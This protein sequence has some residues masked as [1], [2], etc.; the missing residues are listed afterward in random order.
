MP[1]RER[2]IPNWRGVPREHEPDERERRDPSIQ[3]TQAQKDRAYQHARI[4]RISFAEAIRDLF[5][6]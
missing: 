5:E 1:F 6:D 3:L 4:H 2:I